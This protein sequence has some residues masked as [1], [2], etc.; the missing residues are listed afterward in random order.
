MSSPRDSTPFLRSPDRGLGPIV[1]LC[2][3]LSRP[4]AFIGVVGMLVAAGITVA[5]VLARWLFNSGVTGLNEVTAMAFFVGV[6]ACI[7]SGL[8][9]GVSLAVD[10][11]DPLLP[12][13]TAAVSKALGATLM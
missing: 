2:E 3:R 4:I 1:L 10:V 6:T 13:R 11:M 5:D 12:R 7:P 9:R 8:A